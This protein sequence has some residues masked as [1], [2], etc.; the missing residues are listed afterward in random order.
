M[1]RWKRH[2]EPRHVKDRAVTAEHR[3]RKRSP[4]QAERLS[5]AWKE[6]H[7]HSHAPSPEGRPCSVFECNAGDLQ[8]RSSMWTQIAFGHTCSAFATAHAAPAACPTVRAHALSWSSPAQR[9]AGT[10]RS[11]RIIRAQAAGKR[12]NRAAVRFGRLHVI[13]LCHKICLVA[14]CKPS[15][16][17]RSCASFPYT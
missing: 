11:T 7:Y 13:A 12:S 3:M 16:L 6:P 8:F 5:A 4:P 15:L 1:S 17:A 2:T 9:L 10:A 14:V